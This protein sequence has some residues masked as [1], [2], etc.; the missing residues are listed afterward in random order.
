M[1]GRPPDD[2][3][4]AERA[5]RGDE[6]AFEEQPVAVGIP[7]NFFS[8]VADAVDVVLFLFALLVSARQCLLFAMFLVYTSPF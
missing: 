8:P 3:V 4:L 5:R 7:S 1:E 6:R 2:I